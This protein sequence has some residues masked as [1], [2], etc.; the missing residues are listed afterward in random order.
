MLPGKSM[1]ERARDPVLSPP[2]LFDWLELAR[3]FFPEGCSVHG[4][5]KFEQHGQ[6]RIVVPL[7]ENRWLIVE[8]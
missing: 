6:A 5:C 8:V 3:T 7:F 2:S 4:C 1:P